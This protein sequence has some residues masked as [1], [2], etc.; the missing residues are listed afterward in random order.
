VM[1]A[2]V[3]CAAPRAD[4]LLLVKPQFEVGRELLPRGGVV[5]DPRLWRAA[6]AGVVDA[7][8]RRGVGLVAAVVAEP[9][10]PS[11]NR[12][13]FVHLRRGGREGAADAIARAVEEAGSGSR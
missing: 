2:L 6:M 10:G 1:P 4:L 5:R 11:G 9:A 12:E 7:G 8:A 13:F 3:A